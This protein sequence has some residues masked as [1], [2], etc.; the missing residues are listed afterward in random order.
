MIAV[1]TIFQKTMVLKLR[2]RYYRNKAFTFLDAVEQSAAIS[3]SKF[4]LQSI[5]TPRSLTKFVG[6][7]ILL[8]ILNSN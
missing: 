4:N 3:W 5:V 7:K 6:F 8:P 1:S 2:L